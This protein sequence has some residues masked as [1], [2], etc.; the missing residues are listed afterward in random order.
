MQ[1]FSTEVFSLSS[2]CVRLRIFANM[3]FSTLPISNA[4]PSLKSLG[5]RRKTGRGI[6]QSNPRPNQS[7]AIKRCWADPAYRTKRA[8]GQ[9]QHF[10]DRACDPDK[11]SR[12]GIPNGMRRA[13]AYG[14]M[15]MRRRAGQ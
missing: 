14:H 8:E 6:Y 10:L 7:V 11:Y 12:V 13:E 15:G 4:L 1:L 9:K 2:L 5:I 3:T